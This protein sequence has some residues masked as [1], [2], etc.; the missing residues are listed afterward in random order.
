MS[1]FHIFLRGSDFMHS[2]GDVNR[3]YKARSHLVPEGAA[4]CRSEHT[5]VRASHSWHQVTAVL[6]W[7]PVLPNQTKWADS[8]KKVFFPQTLSRKFSMARRLCFLSDSFF[9]SKCLPVKDLFKFTQLK[10]FFEKYDIF[11]ER[12]VGIYIVLFED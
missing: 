9:N 11:L 2:S 4:V 3:I 6:L 1:N 8:L 10:E 7:R 12:D 5:R